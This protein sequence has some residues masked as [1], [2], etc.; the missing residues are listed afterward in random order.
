MALAAGAA[1]AWHPVVFSYAIQPM[2]DV[3]AA[4]LYIAAAALLIKDR[5]VFAFA[6]GLAA[7]AAFLIRTA[8][9]PAVAA[10]A[11]LPLIGGTSR[12]WRVIAFLGI[13]AASVGLQ[14][15]LQWYLYGSPTGNGYGP[16]SEL[17]SLRFLAGNVRS[18]SYWGALMNGPLW[19][20]GAVVGVVALRSNSARVLLAATLLSVA[21]PYAIYRPYDHWQTQRFILPFLAVATSIA[22]LGLFSLSRRVAGYQLG[23]WLG[24]GLTVVMMA[25]WVRWLDREQMFTL[26]RAEERFAQAG[27]LVARATPDNAVI[28]ASLHSGSLRYYTGRQTL[29]W[30]R[31]P[32]GQFDATVD[33]LARRGFPVFLMF[34]GDDEQRELTSRHGD[35]VNRGAWLPSG[36]R[37]DIRLYEWLTPVARR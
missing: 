21:L 17:F 3:P 7:A 10:L 26:D 29:N 9:L 8:L 12:R 20:A 1:V 37:R 33:A 32:E 16:A 36:Q 34:D 15:W 28:L 13:V 25:F 11:L 14:G 30:G 35:V 27:E 6:A 5:P 31:I 23:T 22:A 24:L 4:A 18:Y 19:I 2:S